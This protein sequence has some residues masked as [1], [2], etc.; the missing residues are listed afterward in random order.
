MAK[1][2]RSGK[3]AVWDERTIKKLRSR[4][5]C[6]RQRLIFEISLCTGERMGAIVQLKVNDVYD[7]RGKVLSHITFAKTTRKA[8]KHGEAQTRQIPIHPHLRTFLEQYTPPSQGYLFPSWGISGHI[9]R[10]AVDDYWRRN[11]K[12]MGFTGF[13]THSSR[14]YVINKLREAGTEVSIIAETMRININTV[15]S[16]LRDD[17]VACEKAIASLPV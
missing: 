1:N 3:A 12:D 9:T 13:S 2:N 17:P 4:L 16:Y 10:R 14:H 6:P 7:H 11:L 15:R 8:S 5:T